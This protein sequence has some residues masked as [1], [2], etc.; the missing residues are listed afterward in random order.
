MS[1]SKPI[2]ASDLYKDDGAIKEAITQLQTLQSEYKKAITGISQSVSQ[3]VTQ[4]KGLNTTQKE[5]Q[6]QTRRVATEADKLKAAQDNYVKALSGTSAEINRLKATQKSLLTQ[7]QLE[8]KM[9]NSAVGSY[10]RLSAEY[11]LIKIR[12]NAMSNAEREATAEG[13]RLEARSKSLYERMNVLQKATGKNQLQVGRY[14]IAAKGLNTTIAALEA[15]LAQLAATE[16]KNSQAYRLTTNEIARLKAQ[17]E[18]LTNTQAKSQSSWKNVAGQLKSMA[19]MYV[20]VFGAIR[21]VSSVFSS[22]KEFEKTMSGVKAISKATDDQFIALRESALALGGTTSKT[23]KEVGDLQTEYAKLGFTTQQILDVTKATIM[24]SQATDEDLAKSATTVAGVINAYGLAAYEATRITDIMAASFTSTGLDLEKYGAAMA[25][26]G[27]VA[28]QFGVSVEATSAM[29][30]TL[31]D[32]KIDASKAGTDLRMMFAVLAKEGMTLDQAYDKINA[33]T[34]KITTAQ[35]LF[36]QRAFA[37]SLI[38]AEQRDKVKKLTLAYEDSAGAAKTMADVQIDNLAGSITL[39]SSAWDGLIQN[40]SSSTGVMRSVVDFFTDMLSGAGTAIKVFSELNRLKLKDS[41]DLGFFDRRK[42]EQ[43]MVMLLDNR[44]Q[45]ADAANQTIQDHVQKYTIMLQEASQAD[46][47]YN[48]ALTVMY[49]DQLQFLNGI[50]DRR[51]ADEKDAANRKAILDKAAADKE[52]DEAQKAADDKAKAAEKALQKAIQMED[53][54][55]ETRKQK[56][57]LLANLI[58]DEQQKEL[59][60]MEVS[61]TDKIREFTKLGMDT[62]GIVE[63]YEKLKLSIKQKYVDKETKFFEEL[64]D[65]YRDNA[66]KGYDTELESFDQKQELAQTEF[67]LTKKTEIEKTKFSLEAEKARLQ[68]IL[69][70][71]EKY[72]QELSDTQIQSIKNTIAAIDNEMAA[73]KTPDENGNIDIYSIIGLKLDDDQKQAISDAT[74]LAIEQVKALMDARVQAADA[75]VTAAER[76]TNAAEERLKSEVDARNKGYASNVDAARKNLELAKKTEE[77]A[78]KDRQKAAKQ[79]ILLEGAL[80]AVN[81]IT[82]TAG[83]FKSFASIGPWGI[84]LAIAMSAV[85]W[86]A[87]LGSKAKALQSTK[88]GEGGEFDVEGGTHSSGNDTSLGVHGGIDR[89]VEKGEKVSIFNR[90]AT[91]KYK[92]KLSSIINSINR[93]EFEKKYSKAFTGVGDIPMSVNVGYDSPDLR[94][95]EES[96]DE[97]KKQ[98]NRRFYKDSQG[99]MIEKYKNLKRIYV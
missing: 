11:S 91:A 73:L 98:G 31:V 78:L 67:D 51:A 77:K 61:R 5:G 86:G 26:V 59:A 72:G 18:G 7:K 20:G 89:R 87:F 95:L 97:I 96:V 79:Q 43:D 50:L 12:L 42:L 6:E 84:P 34:N 2:L 70:L 93:G 52:K 66:K 80:Q 75:A 35:D 15:R 90:K 23:A 60:L 83:I 54:A 3:L 44:T 1:G 48:K 92:G 33:S 65:V 32:A 40:M 49:A 58:E 13:Q 9:N 53:K 29:L 28:K 4:L 57:T 24:L 8:E 30:G 46:D 69:T 10:N 39:L 21:L 45:V 27:A 17:L 71:N 37:S 99:R 81:M 47:D 56:Q 64:N 76:E 74:N 55:Y 19:A 62:T 68:T 16:G 36:G 38:L 63:Y 22:I 41:F 82:A 88:Y 14:E 25:N 94:R 85:M